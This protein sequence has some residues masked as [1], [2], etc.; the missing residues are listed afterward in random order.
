M[1]VVGRIRY[2]GTALLQ[3]GLCCRVGGTTESRCVSDRNGLLGESAV[4][5]QVRCPCV[6]MDGATGKCLAWLV[7]PSAPL[8]AF[9]C[10][11]AEMLA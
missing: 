9:C 2:R 3:G 11:V 10:G 4:S 5:K 8:L 7:P 1:G 6:R